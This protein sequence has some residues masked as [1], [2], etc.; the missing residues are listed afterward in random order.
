LFF[1]FFKK[2]FAEDPFKLSEKK[3]KKLFFFPFFSGG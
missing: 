1:I 2:L 3:K